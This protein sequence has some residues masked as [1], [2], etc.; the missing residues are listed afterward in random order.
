[1]AKHLLWRFAQGSASLAPV[2]GGAV[3]RA[4]RRCLRG[5]EIPLRRPTSI[6]RDTLMASTGESAGVSAQGNAGGSGTGGDREGRPRGAYGGRA[7]SQHLCAPSRSRRQRRGGRVP[8]VR[9]TRS[10]IAA[11]VEAAEAGTRVY[12]PG[13]VG[14]PAA[15]PASAPRASTLFEVTGGRE[16]IEE[17]ARRLVRTRKR[18]ARPTR[19]RPYWTSP[20]RATRAAAAWNGAQAGGGPV[21]GLRAVLV[22]AAGPGVLRPPP[23]P[24]RSVLHGP[25]HPLTRRAGLPRRPRRSARRAV[26]GRIPDRREP[27]AGVVL[28]TAPERAPELGPALAVRAERVLETAAARRGYRPAGAGRVG[29][30]R[31]P[32]T[33][34]RRWRARST[35][36]WSKAASRVLSTVSSSASWTARGIRRR[37]GPSS[38]GFATSCGPTT[39]AVQ[40]LLQAAYDRIEPHPID[41]PGL[42][43]VRPC[44]RSTQFH[45]HPPFPPNHPGPLPIG[46]PLPVPV[47]PLA[48]QLDDSVPASSRATTVRDGPCPARR[49]PRTAPMPRRSRAGIGVAVVCGRVLRPHPAGLRGSPRWSRKGRNSRNVFGGVVGKGSH[50]AHVE[51]AVQPAERVAEMVDYQVRAACGRGPVRRPGW[52]RSRAAGRGRG[53]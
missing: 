35:A 14:A 26:R 23:R 8:R 33:I 25:C 39:P 10:M 48:R 32:G 11:S 22:P 31:L 19:W 34:R 38:S 47:V 24:P 42:R 21:P 7:M 13:P 17:A 4:A 52:R 16:R 40:F 49:S 1:M 46:T 51:P 29:L 45:I 50:A 2:A 15:G 30:R 12:G 41:A 44:S 18:G 37:E 28:R 9:R 27:D 53:C 20:R 43:R 36:C 3:C 6:A 5:W